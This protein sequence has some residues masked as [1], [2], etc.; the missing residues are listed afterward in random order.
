MLV[1][2]QLSIYGGLAFAASRVCRALLVPV[3]ALTLWEG[4]KGIVT[5]GYSTPAASISR[6]VFKCRAGK[7]A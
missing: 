4:Q 5:E 7:T 2:M 6:K 3:S 1:G